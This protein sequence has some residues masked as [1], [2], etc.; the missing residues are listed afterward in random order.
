MDVIGEGKGKR[1]CREL[2]CVIGCA[3]VYYS[4]SSQIRKEKKWRETD[5]QT[6]KYNAFV[7]LDLYVRAHNQI[8][9]LYILMGLHF[10]FFFS[11][12]SIS[13]VELI[14][15]QCTYILRLVSH[16]GRQLN[17]AMDFNYTG[18]R[19]MFVD[20]YELRINNIYSLQMDRFLL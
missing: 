2:Y 13:N 14:P 8:I 18:R 3:A 12:L 4:I 15:V 7:A 1:E 5:I 10:P 9:L 11:C 20:Y 6:I 17:F 16:R 19:T